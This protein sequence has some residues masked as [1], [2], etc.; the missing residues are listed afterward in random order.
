MPILNRLPL[1]PFTL[2]SGDVVQTRNIFKTIVFSEQTRSDLS[3]LNVKN[4]VNVSKLDAIGYQLY[5][6][7]PTLYWIIPTINQI[8]SF[9]NSPKPQSSLKTNLSKIYP[10]KV[11]YI[12][13]GK[14]VSNIKKNDIVVLYTDTTTPSDPDP[15]TWKYAGKVKE[16]DETFRRIVVEQQVENTSNSNDLP[17]DANIF[18]FRKEGDNNIL[19][20]NGASENVVLGRTEDEYKKTIT[21]YFGGLNGEEI[22][23]FREIVDGEL[24]TDYSFLDEPSE[25]SLIYKFSNNDSEVLSF[26]FDTTEKQELRKNT[27]NNTIKYLDLPRAFEVSSLLEN[28]FTTGFKRGTEII[29]DG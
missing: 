3:I 28:L 2:P 29:L 9:L 4:G 25:N 5:Q 20:I 6:N 19:I 7:K 8:D 18:I 11:Y 15:L 27:K 14:N 22:S 21:A 10:G 16:Y 17:T 23:P 24:T 1:V 26:F 12:K 13:N